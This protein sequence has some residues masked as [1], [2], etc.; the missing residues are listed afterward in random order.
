MIAQDKEI[1]K[2]IL[3]LTG[4]IQGTRNKV[5]EFLSSFKKFSWLWTENIS[6][7]IA[8]FSKKNPTLQDYEDA[9]K[10]FSNIEDDIEKIEFSHIIGAMELKTTNLCSG[11]RQHAKDWKAQYSHDLHKRARSML[12]QLTEHTK[13]LSTKLSKEVKDIDS[14]GYVMETLEDIRKLQAEIDM[15]FN[16]VQ[17]MYA[18]LD[19]YLPGGITDK[20]E[21]DA[22]SML[23]RNWDSLIQQ[24]EIK[25]KEL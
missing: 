15:K 11:L 12:D 9:L 2:V 18:L 17:E 1:V 6:T 10:R 5:H 14:L 25:G 3:L 16:P 4:S 8:A 24:A 23:K 21:M 13:M 7:N 19:N 20:D 22:R